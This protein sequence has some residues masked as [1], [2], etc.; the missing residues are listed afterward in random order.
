M[1]TNIKKSSDDMKLVVLTNIIKMLINRNF[2]NK[3]N[4]EN[5]II[6]IKEKLN[7]TTYT[8]SNDIQKDNKQMILI[9]FLTDSSITKK[10]S[11]FKNI[12][13]NS[14]INHYIFII[15]DP[16]VTKYLKELKHVSNVELFDYI[17]F[18]IDKASYILT[19]PHRLLSKEEGQQILE[20]YNVTFNQLPKILKTDP[21]VRYYNM[22]SGSICEITPVSEISGSFVRYRGVINSL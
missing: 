14:T 22:P 5:Y 8:F 15:V 7:R 19:P 2:L 13:F 3:T 16:K 17:D 21:M 20:Q 12:E 11:I 9:N 18:F 1:L 4:F 10:Q 6:K